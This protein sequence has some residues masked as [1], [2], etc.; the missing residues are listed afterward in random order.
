MIEVRGGEHDMR[1]PHPHHLLQ[2]RPSSD[3][4]ASVAPRLPCRIE[5]TARPA[6]SARWCHAAGRSLGTHH[7]RA[8]SGRAG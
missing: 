6:G 4:A 5:P 7:R 2:V 3:A 8:R 1:R